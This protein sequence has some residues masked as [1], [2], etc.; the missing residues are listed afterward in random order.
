MNEKNITKETIKINAQKYWA[1][2]FFNV[3]LCAIFLLIF[4]FSLLAQN[5]SILILG[6]SEKSFTTKLTESISY[7]LTQKHITTNIE[8]IDIKAEPDLE[9]ISKFDLIITLGNQPAEYILKKKIKKPV[10]SLL[11]TKRNISLFKTTHRPNN[12]WS[13]LSLDQPIKRQ[14]LLIKHL[15]GKDITI[16]TL[17]GPVSQTNKIEI[18][19]AAKTLDLIF[20]EES[21]QITDQFT[22]ALKNLTDKSDVILAI[23]D[24]VTF[25]KK[26]IRGIL[27]L[28]YRKNI[29]VIGFS[30]S[31]V[32]AG[33]LAAVY[34]NPNQIS[35]QAYEI[36]NNYISTGSLSKNNY[37]PKYFSIDIN[38]KIAHT[39]NI[40]IIDNKKLIDLIKND[41]GLK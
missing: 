13:T 17:F 30:K 3:F 12:L 41:E 26:T 35:Q 36:I 19:K 34:S 32:K 2:L 31:Y 25:N 18:T 38:K 8:L 37:S 9:I 21:T 24:P 28:T 5:T 33:A 14:F 27:L 29:P 6:Q 11:V 1:H 22:S 4:P 10:L 40:K 7:K 16:G 39:L 23:P 15:L 20:I